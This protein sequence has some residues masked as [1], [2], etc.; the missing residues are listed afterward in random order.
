LVKTALFGRDPNW[1]RIAQAAGMALAGEDLEE[2]G[3]DSI[4]AAELAEDVAEAE[5][6]L[7]LDRGEHS[8]HVWFSDLGYEYVRINAEYT[9]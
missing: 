1:G 6:G 3:A 4:N 8:A 2:I 7:R 5:I 9:T